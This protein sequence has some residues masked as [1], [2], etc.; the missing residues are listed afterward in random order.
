MGKSQ[1]EEF[2]REIYKVYAPVEKDVHAVASPFHRA[3]TPNTSG[4]SLSESQ[5]GS[6]FSNPDRIQTPR[7]QQERSS[8][9]VL[10]LPAGT[11]VSFEMFHRVAMKMH[12][13]LSRRHSGLLWVLINYQLSKASNKS[14]N[15]REF[16]PVFEVCRL[17]PDLYLQ[18]VDQQGKDLL[19]LLIVLSFLKGRSFK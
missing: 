16:L 3:A 8:G 2:I 11:L 19:L 10:E 13:S 18:G 12:F 14:D 7:G 17:L 4:N 9:T 6:L 15:V 1:M 5:Y